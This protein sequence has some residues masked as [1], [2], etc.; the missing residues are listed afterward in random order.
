MPAP[1]SFDGLLDLIRKSGLVDQPALDAHADSLRTAGSF[2]S[3]PS[4]LAGT[5]VQDGFLTV[6]QAEQLL[7]GKWRRFSIGKY[8]VLERIG[9]GSMGSVYLCKHHAINRVVAVKV[10]PTSRTADPASVERFYREARAL[11]TLTHANIVRAYDIDQDGDLRF[12]VMEYVDGSSLHHLVAQFGR[13]D[14]VR[15]AHYIAEAA[16]GLQHI[17]ENGIVHRDIEPANI[18]VD[19]SG[20]VK[21]L[22]MGL[23]RFFHDEDDILT[24][25]YDECVL[26]TADYLAPEQA[27]DSHSVDIR[28]DIYSL[29]ATFYYCLT[30]RPPIEDSADHEELLWR[31]TRPPLSVQCLRANVT[32]DL[33][34]IVERMLA[35]DPAERY[36][37]ASQVV[38]ALAPWTQLPIGP[39]PEQEMPQ[40]CP[41][42]RAVINESRT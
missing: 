10:L 7:Q 1:S 34:P 37:M 26:G 18:P 33:V 39:P 3:E 19:R 9:S 24:K 30:G 27:L 21:V 35:P 22:D 15:A 6:F 41:A 40:A 28:A 36:P 5:L 14:P 4:K 32:D 38:D 11:A 12:I 20:V 29:G 16:A 17:H 23:A 13:M 25:K 8:K 2:P 42:V 31:R